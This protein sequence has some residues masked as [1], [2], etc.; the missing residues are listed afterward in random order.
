MKTNLFMLSLCASLVIASNN[1]I[2][3]ELA[4][5]YFTGKN[6]ELTQQEKDAMAVAKKWEAGS[7]QNVK[8]VQGA[9]GSIQF[10]FGAQQTSIVCAVMQVCDIAL[11]A[12]ETITGVYPG[13]SARWTFEPALSGEGANQIQHIIIKPLDVGLETTLVVPTNRRIYHFRLRSHRTEFMPFVS[14]TY[15]EIIQAK[16]QAMHQQAVQEKENKTIPQTGEYLGDLDFNYKVAGKAAW[17]PVRVYNDSVKTIIQMPDTMRQTEA[18]TLLVMRGN[19]DKDQ[20]IVNYRVQGDR[21]IVDAVFDKAI[22]IA[23][24]GRKQDRITITRSN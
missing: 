2:A 9:N 11:Q 18:P 7:A 10:L 23:G 14:F 24:V 22:M 4:D 3:D 1:T 15:P 12:G 5:M 16:W 21:Y 13:D 20:I 6:P 19:S 17:K 8:P